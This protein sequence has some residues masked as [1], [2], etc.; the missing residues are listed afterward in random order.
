MSSDTTNITNIQYTF[1]ELD[2]ECLSQ[3]L[4]HGVSFQGPIEKDGEIHRFTRDRKRE[5]DEWYIAFDG[6]SIR[7]TSYLNCVYGSWSDGSSFK[8]NSW[9]HKS[10]NYSE[11]ELQAIREDWL[12][13]Q[14]EIELKIEEDK[15]KRA[16]NARA[17]WD[18]ASIVPRDPDHESYLRKKSIKAPG[19]RYSKDDYGNPVLVIPIRNA[20]G[21]VCGVQYI[22]ADGTKRIHGL[23]RGH[24]HIIGEVNSDRQIYVCEGY[25]TAASA[26]EA[27]ADPVV[28]AFDCGNLDSV[29]ANLK[30]RHPKNQIIILADDDKETDHNPGRIKAEESVKKYSCSMILPLFPDNFKLPNGKIPTDFNDLHVHFGLDE[31]KR[32]LIENKKL[33]NLSGFNWPEPNPIKASLYPVPA[34]NPEILLPEV[35]RDWVMDEANRMPCPPEFIASAAIVSLGAII[36]ALCAI[37]PKSNDSWLIIPNLWGGIVG[38]PSTKKSPAISAALKPLGKLIAQSGEDLQS[39]KEEYS[40]A[41]IVFDAKKDAIESR[42][43]LAAKKNGDV[44]GAISELHSHQQTAPK[45]PIERRFK[46]N[47]TTIE[48]L[49][50][51]LRDNPAGLLLL[52]DELVG[53]IASWDKAGHEGDRAF[54]LESWNGNASFDTDRIGRGRIHIPNL[55]TSLFG[56]I[57]PDKLMDYLE[58]SANALAND[59]M[60]QR[61]QMLVYPDHRP[62]EWCDFIPN[63][64]ARDRVYILFDAIASLDP[65]DW[66]ALPADDY[67]KFPHFKFDDEAQKIFIHWS[68]DLNL[69]R[70]SNE[71]NPLIAQHLAKFEKL[72]SALALIFHLVDCASFGSYGSIRAQSAQRAV[73]WCEFLEAHARRCY[74][75]LADDGLRSAQ[76]LSD[77]LCK[78]K[79]SNGFTAR[80]VR[81]NQWRYLTTDEAVQAALNWLEDEGWLQVNE[82]GGSGPGSGRR[83]SRY[84]INPKIKQI[85]TPKN[86][87]D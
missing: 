84:N 9:V 85:G 53:L 42:V 76:A 40:V 71:D 70:L 48:K 78:S 18:Q 13:R 30:I 61:F 45:E 69:L 43:K 23:K 47:D 50:E 41:K 38:L 1:A 39:A 7:G 87:D 74:G 67:V 20:V 17:L 26:H 21:E 15:K 62:W 5:K 86:D 80:D 3:M 77:K 19:A 56:G 83:T 60:L 6:V 22:G 10:A 54:Y 11:S 24:F 73:A 44:D 8:Y 49:G 59:G 81:R 2:N 68:T 58:Q 36:G 57:Q 27:N 55:C 64:D 4:H 66:G 46:S 65:I 12:K 37:K 29:I 35:L 52:R 51:I 75:L 72:F 14:K 33:E 63:K 28:V 32:Q 82:V 79:L 25:A 31:V 34:F 16:E